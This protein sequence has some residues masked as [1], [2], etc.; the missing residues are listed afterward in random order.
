MFLEIV[1]SPKVSYYRVLLIKIFHTLFFLN[2]LNY[3]PHHIWGGGR[4]LDYAM[5]TAKFPLCF[6]VMLLRHDTIFSLQN[7]FHKL[8]TQL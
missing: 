8:V 2:K 1:K 3:Q 6:R 7:Y 5:V 4:G